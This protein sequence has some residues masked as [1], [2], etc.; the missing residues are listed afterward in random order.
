M[1]LMMRIR[2]GRAAA[3]FLL[4]LAAAASGC[5]AD[6]SAAAQRI[7]ELDEV[8]VM[9]RQ[10]NDR[11]QADLDAA[12]EKARTAAAD[13]EKA[14]GSGEAYAAAKAALEKRLADLDKS[15]RDSDDGI[16][17]EAVEGGGYR[18]VVQGEILF[19]TGSADLTAGGRAALDKVA[20]AL[21]KSKEN[22][23]VEGHTDNVPIVREA[24][25]KKFPRGNLDLSGAR[26]L[27]V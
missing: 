15:F 16:T 23:R 11:L 18:F 24:T 8:V 10:R 13:A 2:G 26:A 5:V 3:P 17:V 21:K 12:E 7:A 1:N 22:V 14:R 25:K 6:G 20:A 4:V 19:A 27:T 9:Q